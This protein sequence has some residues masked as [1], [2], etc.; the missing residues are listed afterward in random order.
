MAEK[1]NL[2]KLTERRAAPPVEDDLSAFTHELDA[3][4]KE[5]LNDSR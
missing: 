5:L 3:L 2:S 1:V 4:E